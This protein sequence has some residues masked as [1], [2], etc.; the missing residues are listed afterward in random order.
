M[1]NPS[2][3]HPRLTLQRVDLRGRVVGETPL[4]VPVVHDEA[5]QTEGVRIGSGRD[6]TGAAAKLR[7]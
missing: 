4:T 5:M 6:P 1:E 3:A 2:I 7:F